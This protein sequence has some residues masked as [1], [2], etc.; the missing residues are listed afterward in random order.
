[1]DNK[2]KVLFFSKI[3]MFFNAIESFFEEDNNYSVQG[4]SK[5]DEL[6]SIRW[7]RLN[8]IILFDLSNSLTDLDSILKK[9]GN[10]FSSLPFI[11]IIDNEKIKDYIRTK[12]F[13]SYEIQIML[14]VF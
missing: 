4:L 1:M 2:I 3:P 11:F 13:T 5:S 8:A 6:D 10:A 14:Q 12:N 9:R 7:G